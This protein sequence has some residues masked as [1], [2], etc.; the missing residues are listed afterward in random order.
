MSIEIEINI[1]L[2][3]LEPRCTGCSAISACYSSADRYGRNLERKDFRMR[4]SQHWNFHLLLPT[5]SNIH[6]LHPS[7]S[8]ITDFSPVL[9]GTQTDE[10]QSLAEGFSQWFSRQGSPAFSI[11]YAI[12]SCFSGLLTQVSNWEGPSACCERFSAVRWGKLQSRSAKQMTYKSSVYS[13]VCSYLWSSKYG[14]LL[15]PFNFFTAN[16]TVC[17]CRLC[18]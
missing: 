8:V 11:R 3:D 10:K 9:R 18:C 6:F 17:E 16:T 2:V 1:C 5:G 14:T 15:P 12:H 7:T 13:L 4:T